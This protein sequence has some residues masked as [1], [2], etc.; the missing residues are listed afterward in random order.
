M[1]IERVHTTGPNQP[2]HVQRSF[3][4][5]CIL[6]EL[7]ERWNAKELAGLDRLRN[8]DKVLR[9]DAPRAEIQVTDFAVADLSFRKTDGE[10]RR[11]EQRARRSLPQLMPNR[12]LAQLDGIAVA[13]RPEPPPVE[14]HEHHRSAR[15]ARA[16][17]RCHIEGDAS[18]PDRSRATSCGEPCAAT[19]RAVTELGA[20]PR[21][22]RECLVLPGCCGPSC[23]A[24][25]AWSRADRCRHAQRRDPGQCRR[26]AHRVT[27]WHSRPPLLLPVLYTHANTPL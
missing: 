26:L 16:T 10:P 1:F 5:T 9:N 19:A 20:I 13:T 8:A 11:L 27:R 15:G 18:Y 22:R 21:H 17:G 2:N 3:V 14:Y 4:P 7:H 12:R 6:D 24:P 23:R 25:R